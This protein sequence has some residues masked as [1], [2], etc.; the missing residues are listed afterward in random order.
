MGL[1]GAHAD[2]ELLGDF[3]VGG[4]LRDQAEDF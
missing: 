3:G 1:N 4:V 2:N